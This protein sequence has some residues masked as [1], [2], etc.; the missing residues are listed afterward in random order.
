M[1]SAKAIR[2]LSHDGTIRAG[3]VYI[4]STTSP[5]VRAGWTMQEDVARDKYGISDLS[6][7]ETCAATMIE[8]DNG[9]LEVRVVSAPPSL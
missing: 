1:Y 6:I 9:E 8:C 3:L 2:I 7:D 4:K 5:V